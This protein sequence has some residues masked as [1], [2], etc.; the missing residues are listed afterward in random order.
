MTNDMAIPLGSLRA[1]SRSQSQHERNRRSLP[2]H[3]SQCFGA[4]KRK[5]T[6]KTETSPASA[7]SVAT[8]PR[9]MGASRAP[10]PSRS[11]IGTADEVMSRRHGSIFSK[12]TAPLGAVPSTTMARLRSRAVGTR[13][14]ARERAADWGASDGKRD[15]VI[16]RQG[17]RGLTDKNAI[18]REIQSNWDAV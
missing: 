17:R 6:R 15:N 7:A 3:E 2:V 9:W 1:I 5:F 12:G 16:Q 13:S 4:V 10:S 8:V 14:T 11:E 18:Q